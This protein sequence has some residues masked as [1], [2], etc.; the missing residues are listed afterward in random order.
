MECYKSVL[1]HTT[2]LS[3]DSNYQLNDLVLIVNIYL[4]P[5]LIQ[6]DLKQPTKMILEI[7]FGLSCS[8]SDF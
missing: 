6:A 2:L 1:C 4:G 7:L 3:E 5:S 8:N